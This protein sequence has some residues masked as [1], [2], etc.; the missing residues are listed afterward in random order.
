MK[1]ETVVITGASAGLGRATARE[2]G[3]HGA[4]V[5]LLARGVEG[6]EATKREI[7]SMGGAAFVLP[8]DVADAEAVEKAAAA[9]EEKW[10][11]IDIWINNAMASVFSPVKEMTPEEYKRVTDVTYLGVVYGTLAALKR[12]LPRDRGTIVQVGSALAY[13]S[14]PL[15]SAYCAAKHAIAGFTDSLRCELIHDHS[16][17][18]LT[19][20]QMPALNTPQ[21]GWV[22][23]RLKHKAKP[24]PPIFQPEVGAR[25][26]YWASRHARRELYVG[27]PT[28]EAIVANKFAPGALDHYLGRTGF[29]S[30]QTAEIEDPDRP[31]NLWKPVAGD[32]GAHGSF[33]TCAHKTSWELRASLGRLRLASAALV[34]VAGL[35]LAFSHHS[36][37]RH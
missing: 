11:P 4:R 25:A 26:I 5:G 12:M 35:F 9:V 34:T 6:L 24:V 33:D 14:I 19:M 13:R 3:R 37:G 28:V 8:T 18:R 15:Q 10:G 29:R 17:I 32:H 7:E 21:F 23:S 2:F 30:Q 22:R 36:L 27:W 31:D 1:Q 16:H 20:V